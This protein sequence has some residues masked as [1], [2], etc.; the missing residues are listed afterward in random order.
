MYAPVLVTPPSASDPIITYAEAKLHLRVDGDDEKTLI[1]S[2]IAAATAHMD[3]WSG[4]LG[5]CLVTQT[6]R[7]T[8]DGFCREMRLPMPAA[9]IA[10]IISTNAAGV[11]Q[12]AIASTNYQ[13]LHNA[14]GS[15]VRFKDA[16]SF[17]SDLAEAEGVAIS[18]TAGYG[19]AAAVPAAIKQAALLLIAHWYMTREAVNVGNITTELPLGV[20]ALLAPYRLTGI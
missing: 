18:F 3:G 9:T 2:L 11:I 16:Y 17:A 14:L 13:L 20:K 10:S 8:Y 19:A 12:A 6:W 15:F 1:E 7:Q 5:R 4:I